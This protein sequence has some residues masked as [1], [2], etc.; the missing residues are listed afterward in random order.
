VNTDSSLASVV[1][2]PDLGYVHLWARRVPSFLWRKRG[3][4]SDPAGLVSALP[5][6]GLWL[7]ASRECPTTYDQ[8]EGQKR[9]SNRYPAPQC[10]ISE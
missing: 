6:L 2:V 1:E 9:S 8:N 10:L 7:R 4:E 3:I 5:A